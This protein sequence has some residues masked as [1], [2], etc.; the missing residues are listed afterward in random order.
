MH[1]HIYIKSFLSVTA[2]FVEWGVTPPL[3]PRKWLLS[4]IDR[5]T[6]SISQKGKKQ[7]FL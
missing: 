5:Y 4:C 6:L 7:G 3:Y 2:H 1:A